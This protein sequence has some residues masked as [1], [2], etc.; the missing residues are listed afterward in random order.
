[1]KQVNKLSQH[2]ECYQKITQVKLEHNNTK[3][4]NM[5]LEALLEEKDNKIQALT[6][7]IAHLRQLQNDSTVN[8]L[9]NNE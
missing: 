7:E 1:M 5:Q 4:K 2:E 3:M 6:E 9:F 8:Q